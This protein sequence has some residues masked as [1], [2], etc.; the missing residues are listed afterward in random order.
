M[1]DLIADAQ[2]KAFAF[3]VTG[4]GFAAALEMFKREI[5]SGGGRA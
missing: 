2:I 3:A 4:A 1:V 5:N